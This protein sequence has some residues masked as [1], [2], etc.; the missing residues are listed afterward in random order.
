MTSTTGAK[1]IHI[2]KS[3]RHTAMSG[4]ALQF[5]ETDL[6]AIAEVYD[7]T[8]HESPLVI[9]HPKHDLPAYG[10]VQGLAFSDGSDGLNAGLWATPAQV[11]PDFADMVAAGAFKKISAAFY[12]PDAP[13]NPTPGSFYLRHVGFLGAQPPAVK[14]L[15]NPA[16]ADEEAGV[17][18]VEFGEDDSSTPPEK[19]P[20]VTEEEAAR[21]RAENEAQAARIAQLE[22]QA[23]S[24]R[25]ARLHSD[26]E[27]FA[28][29]LVADGRLVPAAKDVIV[30]TL[31]HLAT[32]DTP[33][34]FGEGES[35]APLIDALKATLK[36]APKL[37]EFGESATRERASQEDNGTTVDSDDAAFAE[38]ADP[39]RLKQHKA[40]KAHMAQ[41]KVD[42]A[43]AARAVLK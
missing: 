23:Q 36:A 37:V 40:I 32:Q 3:G 9:G 24:E 10:W 21:L 39:E 27:A 1:P 28:D 2:F 4:R 7:P 26:N 35:K 11:N 12:S 38:S 41:H 31:D 8:K 15:R 33:I 25:T 16:F 20:T 6:Q 18:T 14:G 13:N 30:A 43:T 17:I 19:E 42:Y 34:E 5:S 29:T 22:A